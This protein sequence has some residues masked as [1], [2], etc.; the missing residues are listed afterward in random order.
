MFAFRRTSWIVRLLSEKPDGWFE[1]GWDEEIADAFA[2]VVEFLE[3]SRGT[4]PRDWAWG[5]LRQLEFKHPLGQVKAFRKIFNH[6]PF[7]WGGD[8]NTIGQ[9]T[10]ASLDPLGN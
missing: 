6:G 10:N 4:D 8:T 1:K 5:D 3:S 9:A 2:Y 7:S